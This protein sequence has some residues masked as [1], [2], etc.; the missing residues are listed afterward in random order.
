[1]PGPLEGVRVIELGQLVAG[2][3]CGQ[4]L[5]D[6]G[7]EVIKVEDPAKGD[8]LRDWGREK[9]EGR[10]LWWP[11]AAR[12]KTCITIDLRHARGQELIRRLIDEADIVLENFR[13]GTM[14]RW[15]LGY[16]QLSAIN[17]RLVMIR[18]SGYGQDGPYAQRPGYA[19][20]GEAMGGL[21]YV[22]G[23]P[24]SPPSRAG[25]SLGDSLAA[26]FGCMGG[27]AAYANAQRTGQGQVVDASIYESVLGV[28]ESLVPEYVLAGF[29]RERTGSM[30]PNVAPSN[31]YPSRDGQMVIIAANNDTLWC[32][33]ATAMGRPELGTDPRFASHTVRGEHQ[34]ELDRLIAE[35]TVTL[36]AAALV[37]HLQAHDVVVG[38]MYRAPEMLDDPQ[39]VARDSIVNVAHPEFGEF[40]MQNVFPKFSRTPA[41]VLWC[42]PSHGE[43]TAEVLGR[44]LG[45]TTNE[46]A[47]LHDDGV[48]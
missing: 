27:L 7:C 11:I 48:I 9:A 44:L 6:Y 35:W 26:M 38:S 32:R 46:L 2:P 24:S 31:V 8:P 45:I 22:I 15:G 3:Y 33:L 1:M 36:D 25:I 37:E 19:S 16:E 34:G 29:I 28:M 30:L 17:P 12:N 21:R 39:F 20:V 23:D 41:E 18:V 10:S 13:P 43:H 42:G 4:L 5:A 47:A 40:P 14:E